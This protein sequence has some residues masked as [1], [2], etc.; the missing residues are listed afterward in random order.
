[1]IVDV[2]VQKNVNRISQKF[3]IFKQEEKERPLRR[4]ESP[5]SFLPYLFRVRIFAVPLDIHRN[6]LS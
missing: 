4:C 1:M 2:T 3:L 5:F 6:D